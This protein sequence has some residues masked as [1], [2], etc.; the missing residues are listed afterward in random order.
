MSNHG[1]NWDEGMTLKNEEVIF[2]LLGDYD[3]RALLTLILSLRTPRMISVYISSMV[4]N[5]SKNLSVNGLSRDISKNGELTKGTWII[6]KKEGLK[7]INILE[8]KEDLT[9]L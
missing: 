6:S 5:L 8:N 2:N 9:Y 7:Y 4:W 1:G 3:A